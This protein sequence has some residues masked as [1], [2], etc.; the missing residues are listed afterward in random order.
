MINLPEVD[1]VLPADPE[2]PSSA[3]AN[4]SPWTALVRRAPPHPCSSKRVKPYA[5]EEPRPGRRDPR[6]SFA[7][8]TSIS[9]AGHRCLLSAEVVAQI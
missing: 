3:H 6:S 7:R 8:A 5:G 1:T 9:S 4:R 2:A